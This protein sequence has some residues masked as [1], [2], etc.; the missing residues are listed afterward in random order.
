MD[1]PRIAVFYEPGQFTAMID[2]CMRE[3]HSIQLVNLK[4]KFAVAFDGFFAATLVKPTIQEQFVSIYFEEVLRA[5]NRLCRP[6]K[7]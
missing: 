4:S 1:R 5:S 7:M 3:Q 6:Q 2:M